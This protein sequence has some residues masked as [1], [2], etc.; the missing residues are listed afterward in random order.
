MLSCWLL[1][2]VFKLWSYYHTMQS[3]LF[4][5]HQFLPDLFAKLLRHSKSNAVFFPRVYVQKASSLRRSKAGSK[6][7]RPREAHNVSITLQL[8]I[9]VRAS[10][11][12]VTCLRIKEISVAICTSL[13]IIHLQSVKQPIFSSIKHWN[14]DEFYLFVQC[15]HL[16]FVIVQSFCE[17]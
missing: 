3:I 16:K 13:G 11:A 9:Q 2:P 6:S 5:C 12:E 4:K 8:F 7:L 10:P 15:F 17:S 1:D 14:S